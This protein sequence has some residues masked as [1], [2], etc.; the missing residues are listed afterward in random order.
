L[1]VKLPAGGEAVPS[2]STD[3]NVGV[4]RG[5][6]SIAVGRALG[7]EQHTLQEWAESTSARTATKQLIL[8]AVA[9]TQKTG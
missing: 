3:A 1:N 4:V 2:G 7:G 8:L 5:I 6:P 9:L